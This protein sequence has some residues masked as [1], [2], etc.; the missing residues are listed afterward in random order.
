MKKMKTLAE[1][2]KKSLYDDM[3]RLLFVSIISADSDEF[4]EDEKL[5]EFQLYNELESNDIIV[6]VIGG[7]EEMEYENL[8]NYL[9]TMQYNNIKYKRSA[10]A[11]LQ[12]FIQD[13][14]KNAEAAAQIVDNFDKEKYQNVVEFAKSANANRP[15]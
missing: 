6:Q 14:P 15:I 11:L 10:A 7:M 4:T 13:L 5:D 12:S 2:E 3:R 8:L 9:H 1:N